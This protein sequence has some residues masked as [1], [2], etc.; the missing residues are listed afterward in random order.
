MAR[1]QKGEREDRKKMVYRLLQRLR[2][3]IREEEIA[4]ELGWQRR[5]LNNYLNGLKEDGKAYREGRSWF[6]R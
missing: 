1:L 2:W 6:A 3:G 4:E 5:T